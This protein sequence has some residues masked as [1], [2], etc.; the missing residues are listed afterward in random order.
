MREPWQ[1][2][3]EPGSAPS[4]WRNLVDDE[5][6]HWIERLPLHHGRDSELLEIVDSRRHFFIRQEAAKRLESAEQLKSR[7]DD[8]HVGQI[9]ARRLCRV[10]DVDYLEQLVRTSRH[11][12]VRKAAE[13]QLRLLR[14]LL[15]Q[16]R[17]PAEHSRDQK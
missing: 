6:L 9:L 8:R 14:A 5:L 1:S 13:A 16:A 10:E 11:L 15:A 4:S 3:P 7:R 2:G 12:E 17:V